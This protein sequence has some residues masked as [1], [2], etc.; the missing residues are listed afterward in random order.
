MGYAGRY[1]YVVVN[2]Q[3]DTA[4]GELKAVIAAERLRAARNAKLIERIRT[5]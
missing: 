2:D 5:G 4:C 1:D 3:L